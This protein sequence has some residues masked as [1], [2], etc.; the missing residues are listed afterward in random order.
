MRSSLPAALVICAVVASAI[1]GCGGA[2][3][4]SGVAPIVQP[5]P[6]LAPSPTPTPTPIQLVLGTT[7]GTDVFPEGDT[8][9]GGQGQG[10]DGVN[11]RQAL[12]NQ[13]HH[14]VHL[15][16]FV[17]G[18][19]IALPRGTGMKN[20]NHNNF[21]YHADCFYFLHTHD[22]TGIIHIEPPDGT[23]FGLKQYFDI[24]GE[25]LSTNGFAG[26][27]GAVAVYI[28]GTLQPGMDPTTVTFS[29]FEEIT[30]VIGTPPN[31][32]PEY[33]FPAGYP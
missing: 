9:S 25:P 11:C 26:Y 16:M 22:E 14:H 21:I 27:A 29:P 1:A 7:V 33:L 3:S 19:Q 20:P 23:T 24:W 12:D 18:E 5:S 13:F 30:L 32:I 6:T 15:S 4:S 8:S 31:W 28:D 10:I 17:N 2:S